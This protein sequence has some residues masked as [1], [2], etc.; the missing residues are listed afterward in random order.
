MYVYI[1]IHKCILIDNFYCFVGLVV[2]PLYNPLSSIPKKTGQ[3]EL[4][5]MLI[6]SD[7]FEG[8][9][10]TMITISITIMS[11]MTTWIS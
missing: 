7:I 11:I 3:I 4:K 9:C 1:Y 8:L 5:I 10:L 6:P 2:D